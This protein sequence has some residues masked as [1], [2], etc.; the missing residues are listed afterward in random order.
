MEAARAYSETLTIYF[1]R[2]PE[3]GGKV[4]MIAAE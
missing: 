4:R 3:E 1:D 2:A